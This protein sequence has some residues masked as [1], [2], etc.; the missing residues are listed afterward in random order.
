M[1]AL[2]LLALDPIAETLADP[3]SYGLR[4]ERSGADAMEQ[5]CNALTRRPCPQWILEGDIKSCFDRISHEWLLAH[6]P[7]E[8]AIL[9]Q[10]LKAGYMEK[11]LFYQ[12]ADGTPQGGISSPVLANMAL[13]GLEGMRRKQYHCSGRRAML[14]MNKQVNVVRYAEDFIITGLSKE[15]LEEEIT[16]RVTAFL[17][18]RGLVLSE[19]KTPITHSED[20]CDFLGQH[21]RQYDGK[22]WI[23]PSKKNV[24]TFLTDIR[25][26]MK[27]NSDI[28]TYDLIAR[29]NPTRRGWANF[30]R[31]VASKETVRQVDTALF[32]A[33]WRWARRRHPNKGKHWVKAKDFGSYDNQHWRFFGERKDRKGQEVKNWLYRTAS[34]P[35]RRPVKIKG[36]CN[37]Y[38]PTWE[39][40]LEQ[41]LGVKR[42]HNLRGKRLLKHLWRE[43]DGICP[44]CHQP[45]TVV[46][47]WHNHH[48][49]HKTLGGADNAE[50]RLLVHPHCHSQIHAKGL[51]VSKPRP[52]RGVR[53]IKAGCRETD[54]S[55]LSGGEGW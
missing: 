23:K 54:L 26:V 2:H 36:D 39:I 44:V 55:G 24:K 22:L 12:T 35:I 25:E 45:I 17:R 48:I 18:E 15:I 33:L 28:K 14:G 30:H 8:K 50:N 9:Q 13:D 34:T 41:R 6:I 10:G 16:P 38:D 52:S 51:S 4:K 7:M 40:Y 31:Y 19:E 53:E 47:G 29:L 20:G 32:Q 5:C 21:V 1:Q 46:T 27:G 43:Q 49:V 37:P 11:S 3:N 42:E